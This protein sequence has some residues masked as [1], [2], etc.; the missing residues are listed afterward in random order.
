MCDDVSLR[1]LS[2]Y[3][4]LSVHVSSLFSLVDFPLFP[5]DAFRAHLNGYEPV[6]GVLGC[7][8]FGSET[9]TQ[10]RK[11]LVRRFFLFATVLLRIRFVRF[12]FWL[13][14]VQETLQSDHK[15]YLCIRKFLFAR[16]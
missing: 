13:T 6:H 2:L 16:K 10:I 3:L 8:F 1:T 5:V 7:D 4:G 14:I 11:S 15:F 9:N 12:W